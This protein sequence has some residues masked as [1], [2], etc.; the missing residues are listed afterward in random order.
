MEVYFHDLGQFKSFL[1]SNITAKRPDVFPVNWT[2]SI[3][4]SYNITLEMTDFNGMPTHQKL[5]H[6]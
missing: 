2:S 1:T 4:S 5:F 6:A 3:Y